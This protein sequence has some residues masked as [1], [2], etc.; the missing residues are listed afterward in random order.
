MPRAVQCENTY[1]S[2][3]H[4]FGYCYAAAA[5]VQGYIHFA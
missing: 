2:R 1:I 3:A 4:G 5:A